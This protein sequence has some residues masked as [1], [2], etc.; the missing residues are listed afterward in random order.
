MISGPHFKRAYTEP[1]KIA[2]EVAQRVED[3]LGKVSPAQKI[4]NSQILSAMIGAAGVALFIVG[5]ERSFDFLPGPISILIGLI[6][7]AI[8]GT[9][10]KKL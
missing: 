8:S 3:Y 5:I 9:L 6:F 2:D 1:D 10:L 4:R 7:L